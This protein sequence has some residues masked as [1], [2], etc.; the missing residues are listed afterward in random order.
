MI[1][2]RQRLSAPP[3]ISVSP[4]Y[5]LRTYRPG[6]ETRFYEVMEIAGFEGWNEEI[7]RP[8]LAKILPDGWFVVTEDA[9]GALVATTMANHNP[10]DRHPFGGELG[11]VASD[12][13]HKGRG[14]GMIVCAA[15]INRFLSAGYRNIYL[16]TDDFR[17]PAIKV[18]LRLGFAPLLFAPDMHDRWQHICDQLNWPFTPADWPADRNYHIE[19]E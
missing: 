18:Y 8:W 16:N 11:W 12:L 9:T 3:V 13:A 19:M 1:W 4:G 15:V 17:L 5:T 14:L 10:T 2:P 7:L 6:D